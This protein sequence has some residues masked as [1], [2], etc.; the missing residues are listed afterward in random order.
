MRDPSAPIRTEERPKNVCRVAMHVPARPTP[1]LPLTWSMTT[2]HIAVPALVGD[3]V[4]AQPPQ[5]GQPIVQPVGVGPDP[6]MIDPT[7]RRA[8]RINWG[9]PVW[10]FTQV[11][12]INDRSVRST[13]VVE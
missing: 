2:P 10:P 12:S 5:F 1:N 7:V 8:M 9:P 11:P 4:D 3:L 6:A 13:P